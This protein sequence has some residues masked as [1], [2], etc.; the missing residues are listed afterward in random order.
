MVLATLAPIFLGSIE[1]P[2]LLLMR[3]RTLN[4]RLKCLTLFPGDVLL[5]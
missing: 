1:F 2:I 3:N 5:A 4:R